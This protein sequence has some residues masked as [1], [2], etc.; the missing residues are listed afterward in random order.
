MAVLPTWKSMT[1]G[2]LPSKEMWDR[3]W[4]MLDDAGELRNSRY[5]VRLSTSDSRAVDGFKL[6]DDAWKCDELWEAITEIVNAEPDA[7]TVSEDEERD[8]AYQ[9]FYSNLDKV[10]FAIDP[11]QPEYVEIGPDTPSLIEWAAK[12][13]DYEINCRDRAI[14]ALNYDAAYSVVGKCFAR[15]ELALD[16]VSSIMQTMRF[17][18]I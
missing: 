18:W 14:I 5:S 4:S 15:R 2:V 11:N 9:I 3:H 12:F 6:G 16:L 8:D 17:E 1:Y 7:I 10:P 13:A